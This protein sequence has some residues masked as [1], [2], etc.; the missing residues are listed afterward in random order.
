MKL[1][2]CMLI[3]NEEEI[4]DLPLKSVLGIVDEVVIVHD[5]LVKDD[6][7][8]IVKCFCKKND[9]QL[10]FIVD[11]KHNGHFGQQRQMILD[12]ATHDWILWLDADECIDEQLKSTIKKIIS[13]D[14]I[15]IDAFHLE[16]QHFINDFSN[17]DNSIELHIGLFRL[18]RNNGKVDLKYMKNHALPRSSDFQNIQ[19]LHSG[20][21]W[22][23]GY[24]RG[25]MKNFERY[26]RNI[27]CSEI[28]SPYQMCKWRDRHLLGYFPTRKI[29]INQ[30]P[31]IIKD[32][33]HLDVYNC[34]TINNL[35]NGEK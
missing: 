10:K 6:T 20:Y 21:I 24:L 4:I 14:T 29:N 7:E 34:E 30:I 33:F 27:K 8:K 26:L 11:N 35:I 15:N 3:K 18:Y 28:H 22:H 25:A 17:I 12:N 23:L 9:I 32:R 19:A 31:Q 1:S 2:L 16:Y 5:G 13:D